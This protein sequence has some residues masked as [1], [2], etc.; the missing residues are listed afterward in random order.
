MR[1]YIKRIEI[2]FFNKQW[3]IEKRKQTGVRKVSMLKKS[4]S[5]KLKKV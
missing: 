5:I 1:S 4:T 3:Q 2:I